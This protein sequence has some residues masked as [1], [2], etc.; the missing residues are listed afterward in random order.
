MYFSTSTEFAGI[1]EYTAH[2]Y[3]D[4]TVYYYFP[5]VIEGLCPIDVTNFPFDTQIC[6]LIFSSWNYHGQEIDLFPRK[7]PGDLS[8]MK[9]NTEWLVPKISV[10]RHVVWYDAY[11]VPYP[12]ITF[13]VHLQRKPAYY[14]TNILLPSTMI[15]ILAILGYFL[16]V[17]SGEKVSLVITVM[18]AMSVFQLL[19]ADKLPASADSTPWIS[20]LNFIVNLH[21]SYEILITNQKIQIRFSS[22]IYNKRAD[23]NM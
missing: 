16:P 19:V 4:G 15:T 9:S 10:V 3:S 1:K 23:Y 13:Y 6:A 5:T 11:P 8:N 17:E 12:D 14:I 7:N 20:M 22:H 2:I 18:L 21:F